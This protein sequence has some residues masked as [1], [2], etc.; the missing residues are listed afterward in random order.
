MKTLLVLA[1][2]VSYNSCKVLDLEHMEDAREFLTGNTPD[3]ILFSIAKKDGGG[4]E[5]GSFIFM[6]RPVV[7]YGS[8]DQV[9]DDRE[10]NVLANEWLFT[11]NH[12]LDYIK[13]NV[14]VCGMSYN[15][16]SNVSDVGDIIVESFQEELKALLEEGE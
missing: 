1:G 10:L 9:E 3:H 12:V 4:E 11:H 6:G 7:D 13:G 8:K 5:H 14:L 2:P 15:G 16:T